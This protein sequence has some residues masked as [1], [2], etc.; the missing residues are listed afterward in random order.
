MTLYIEG[1]DDGAE[2]KDQIMPSLTEGEV[3]ACRKLLPEQ[4]FTQ[5]PPRYT[6][7]TLVKTME[8]KGIGRHPPTRRPSEPS[9]TAGMWSGIAKPSSQPSLGGW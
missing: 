7:A 1:T 4:H 9:S 2:E 6:E 3:L 8:E 5:P